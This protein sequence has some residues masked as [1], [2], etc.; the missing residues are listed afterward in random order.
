MRDDMETYKD[1]KAVKAK[2]GTATEL[3]TVSPWCRG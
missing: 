2:T 1:V 3:F